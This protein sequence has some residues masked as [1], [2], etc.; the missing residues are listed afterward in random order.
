MD[1]VAADAPATP[2]ALLEFMRLIWAVDHELQSI[3]KRMLTRLGLTVPQRMALLLI[4]RTPGILA[5]DLAELLYLHPG[6]ISGVVGRLESAGLIVRE[7]DAE[8][9]RRIR[10]TLTPDGQTANRRHEGTFEAA[11]RRVLVTAST[12]DL[13][14]TD[15]VL[16]QLASQLRSS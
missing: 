7:G 1:T 11:V 12:R 8:D 3:S 10:L 9:A 14:A 6:T 4:G 13:A 15:R 2:D 5:S 16:T